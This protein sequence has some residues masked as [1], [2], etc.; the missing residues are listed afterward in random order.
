MLYVDVVNTKV[1]DNFHILFVLKFHDF[2]PAGLGVMNFTS[3]RSGF[4]YVRYRSERLGCLTKINTKS[5]LV[6]N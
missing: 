3:F 1:V 5:S 2:R 6:H 4:T